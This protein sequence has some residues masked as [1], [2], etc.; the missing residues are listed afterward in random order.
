MKW[1]EEHGVF[2]VFGLA[3]NPL[4]R[5]IIAP[6]MAQAAR[7]HRRTGR[8]VRVFCEFPHRT[9]TGSWSR[10]RRVVAKAEQIEGKENPRFVVTNLSRRAWAKQALYEEL[11]CARGEMENRIKEQLSLFATRVSAATM[12][13]NQLRLYF[14]ALA[15]VLVEGLRRLGLQGTELARAQAG[16]IRLR[17]LKIGARIRI[18]VRKIWVSLAS[19]FP[20]RG[21]FGQAWVQLRC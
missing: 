21:L 4:L 1:C 18:T 9:K 3:R 15:Y 7:Q 13:A 19:S 14:A 8:A 12:R 11:Y 17:L 6:Q 20:L 16:T 10:K 5:R 2:Y